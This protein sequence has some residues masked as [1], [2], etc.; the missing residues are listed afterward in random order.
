[1]EHLI[2]STASVI[3]SG[4]ANGADSTAATGRNDKEKK[5]RKACADFEAIFTY[6][7]FQSMR[8]TIPDSGL[9]NKFPGKDTYDMMVDQKVAEELSKRSN[10]LGLKEMLYKQMAGK[11][12]G[13]EGNVNTMTPE[14][15]SPNILVSKD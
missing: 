15:T 6:Q 8:H 7:L 5:L 1:M 12:L 14:K 9:L 3:T 4:S 10:G 11:V 13:K 2:K